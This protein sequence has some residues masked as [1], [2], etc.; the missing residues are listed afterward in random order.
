VSR[1]S[2]HTLFDASPLLSAKQIRRAKS[3]PKHNQAFPAEAKSH[4]W[5]AVN[6]LTK[7]K[8]LVVGENLGIETS[9]CSSPCSIG[10]DWEA[11]H[12]YFMEV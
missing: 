7:Y 2:A 1:F 8:M 3:S 4:P 12:Y 5:D 9:I 10:E 11:N 6:A